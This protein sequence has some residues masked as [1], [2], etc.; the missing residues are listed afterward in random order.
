M[1]T[2]ERCIKYMKARNEQARTVACVAAV[3][4]FALAVYFSIYALISGGVF[5]SLSERTGKIIAVSVCAVIAA[6]IA[7]LNI[8]TVIRSKAVYI[9]RP[10]AIAMRDS[11]DVVRLA[12]STA[13]PVLIY[14]ITCSL[15]I[16]AVAA[17]VYIILQMI[18]EDQGLAHVYGKTAISLFAAS[19][20]MIA[21][22][23]LDRISCYRALLGETHELM[24]EPARKTAAAAIAAV[25]VPACICAWY[26]LRFYG[27]RPDIAWAI[28]P[29]TALFA[30]AIAFL[31]SW[32][33][34]PAG[35]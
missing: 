10:D 8:L 13:R 22:P 34:E 23:C 32:T 1:G 2:D 27:N 28:F 12:Y 26:V 4:L 21:Y 9:T 24:Y 3:Q 5:Y 14:K 20:V 19:A 25:A 15:V 35:A 7:V 33:R 6:F 17:I 31:I 16:M 29:F 18:V 11:E 30:F